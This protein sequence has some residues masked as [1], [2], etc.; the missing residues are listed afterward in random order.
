MTDFRTKINQALAEKKILRSD[1]IHAMNQIDRVNQQTV[2]NYLAGKSEL[3]TD[4]LE[5]MLQA[6]ESLGIK[7]E[8]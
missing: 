1:L 6:L 3:Q 4:N 8:L 2:Y 5:V 7:I